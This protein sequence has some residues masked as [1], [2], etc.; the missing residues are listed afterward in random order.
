MHIKHNRTSR[1]L[2]RLIDGGWG[3]SNIRSNTK[4]LRRLMQSGRYS[5][6]ALPTTTRRHKTIPPSPP[7]TL[8]AGGAGHFAGERNEPAHFLSGKGQILFL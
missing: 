1:T 2:I 8:I 7:V 3:I 4:L 6:P 5:A